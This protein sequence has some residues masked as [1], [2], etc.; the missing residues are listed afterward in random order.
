MPGTMPQ[1]HVENDA[2]ASAQHF[3]S[4]LLSR[5]SASAKLLVAPGPTLPQLQTMIAAAVTAPDHG[6]LRPWRFIA[7][8]DEA[9]ETL[10]ELF[11]SAKARLSPDAG[12]DELQRERE[13]ALRAP[14][15]LA[16][17]ARVQ[18]HQPRVEERDQYAS[19]GAAIQNVLLAAHAMGYGAIMLSG[20][21]T[22]D[23]QL[24]AALGLT[25]QEELIG[26]ICLGTLASPPRAKIR[27]DAVDHLTIWRGL[28]D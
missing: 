6:N 27:P 23:R 28:E 22:R 13:R 24:V 10:G 16:V 11:L 20:R 7:N 9:R 8:A 3:L 14:T 2:D 12:P 21:K 1:D 4:V 26:F 15:L 5:R 17:V 19:V 25:G 18:R